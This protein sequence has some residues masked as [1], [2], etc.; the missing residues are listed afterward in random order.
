MAVRFRAH[1]KTAVVNVHTLGEVPT[2]SPDLYPAHACPKRILAR[3][4]RDRYAD[5]THHAPG[6]A[7]AESAR[8]NP[9]SGSGAY[10]LLHVTVQKLTLLEKLSTKADIN[11]IHSKENLKEQ[12]I[13]YHT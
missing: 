4:Q 10:T 8:R 2:P 6:Q 13:L 1:N 3:V 7:A 11:V 9:G 5:Q 12:V